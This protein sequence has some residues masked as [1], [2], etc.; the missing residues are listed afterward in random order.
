MVASFS[1]LVWPTRR[2]GVAAAGKVDDACLPASRLR[3]GTETHR[4]LLHDEAEFAVAVAADIDIVLGGSTWELVFAPESEE[5]DRLTGSFDP[6]VLRMPGRGL[7]RFDR[8]GL[9]G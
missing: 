6:S 5:L 3:W 2:K 7:C 9:G 8:R 1:R 4:D